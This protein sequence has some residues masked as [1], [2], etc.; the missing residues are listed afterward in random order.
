MQVLLQNDKIAITA[1]DIEFT[2]FVDAVDVVFVMFGGA[3]QLGAEFW[4]LDCEGYLG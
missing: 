2:N 1:P 3:A 4:G